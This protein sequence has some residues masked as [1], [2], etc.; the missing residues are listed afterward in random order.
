M[1][2]ASWTFLSILVVVVEPIA[3]LR[4]FTGV[5][6][7]NILLLDNFLEPGWLGGRRLKSI[8]FLGQHFCQYVARV[9]SLCGVEDLWLM[10]GRG[11][12]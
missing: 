10:T 8:S 11:Y 6:R 1:N 2:E 3:G 5:G 7:G 12:I 4:A 9:R